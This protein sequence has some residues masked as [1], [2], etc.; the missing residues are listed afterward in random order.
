RFIIVLGAL[1]VALSVSGQSARLSG[2]IHNQQGTAL[3]G[4]T[5]VVGDKLASQ[6]TDP[7]GKFSFPDLPA[8]TYIVTISH[9]GYPEYRATVTLKDEPVTIRIQLDPESRVLDDVVVTGKSETQQVREQP[10]RAVVVDTRAAAEQ[11]TTLAELMNR[12]P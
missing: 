12:S 8:G 11:P 5:V 1:S 4:A 6:V 7:S 10:I 2:S 3:S 9:V